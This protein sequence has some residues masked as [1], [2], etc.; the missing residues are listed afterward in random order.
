VVGVMNLSRA[1]TAAFSPL[2]IRLA[3]AVA[4][5]AGL[6]IANARLYAQTLDLSFT[7]P[8]TG[9]P[10]RRALFLRLDQEWTRA[11][12]FGD[13]LSV[14]MVDLDNF[15][16]INDT[17]GH[18]AGDTV[19][20]AVATALLRNV[21]KVDLVARYGGEEFCVLLPRS[22]LAEALDVAEKLRRAVA[23]TPLPPRPQQ[24][25]QQFPQQSDSAPPLRLTVS[26]G[27]ASYG[28]EVRDAQALIALADAALYS[29]KRAGRD[30]VKGAA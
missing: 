3:E 6:A 25:P 4:A 7:D 2:E 20:R 21:R 18:A 28:P 24:S 16:A 17:W 14:L 15:K 27:V 8:L 9:A 11:V 29:A 1:R 12:R 5:Q 22:T 13:E 23:Q 19:L 26:L 10:N 30:R